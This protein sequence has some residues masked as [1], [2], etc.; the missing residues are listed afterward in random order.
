V[1]LTAIAGLFF[2]VWLIKTASGLSGKAHTT[3]F[4][5]LLIAAEAAS[6]L[7]LHAVR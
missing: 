6:K 4:V 7:V 5:L 3:A 2:L 1:A